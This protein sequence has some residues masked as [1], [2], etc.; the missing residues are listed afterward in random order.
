MSSPPP[1][2]LT[3]EDAERIAETVRIRRERWPDESLQQSIM[4]VVL[5]FGDHWTSVACINGEWTGQK[6]DLETGGGI[7]TCPNGHVMT[8][9]NHKVL[10]VIDDPE[11]A[12]L[13]R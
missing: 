9:F 13:P 1:S 10:G 8:E 3:V 4:V 5:N 11:M 12:A 6:R 2:P 7:P